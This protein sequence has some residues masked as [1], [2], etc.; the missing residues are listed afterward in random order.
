MHFPYSL[1]RTLYP[2]A[3]VSCCWSTTRVSIRALKDIHT[4]THPGK[5]VRSVNNPTLDESGPT[6]TAADLLA[7]LDAEADLE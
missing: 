2:I 5:L 6:V 4:A 1:H 7:A 3:G